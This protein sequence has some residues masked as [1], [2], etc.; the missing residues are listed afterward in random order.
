MTGARGLQTSNWYK[1]MAKLYNDAGGW[2][3]GNDTY[4][5]E[6]VIYNT[7]GSVTT[8]KDLLTRAVLQDG[9]KFMLGWTI[10][11]SADVDSTVTELNKVI[12]VNADMTNQ[13]SNP[14]YNYMYPRGMFFQ[15]ADVYKICTDM[16]KKG[17]KSYVSVKPDSQIGRTMDPTINVA[18]KLSDPNIDYKGTVW[19]SPSTVDWGPIATKIKSYNAD[20]ADIIYLG[21]IPQSIPNIYRALYDVGFKG[22]I[23]P[24]QMSQAIL[25][26]LVVTVGKAAIEGGEVPGADAYTWQTEP[27]MRSLM[28]TYVKEY[29]K[30]ESDGDVSEFLIIEAAINATQSVDTDVIKAWWDN[31]PPPI[32]TRGGLIQYFARPDVGNNRTV[33]GCSSGQLGLIRDGKLVGSGTFTAVKDH[34][35]LTIKTQNFVDAYKAYWEKYGYPT[36]PASQKGTESFH[37]TDIGITGKD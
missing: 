20:C 31:S 29:G 5:V 21:Y 23:L 35:L 16:V 30:W 3:I 26:A 28:D 11:G 15:N 12:V 32:Q 2:K 25:D 37:Y 10:T 22:Y 4:K 36:F 27:R 6:M 8:A 13:S 1:L 18:W 24:G 14:K 17:V 34:Y 33:M 9:C 19:V 7:Q